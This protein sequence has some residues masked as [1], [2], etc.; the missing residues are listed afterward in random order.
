MKILQ[1][2]CKGLGNGGVQ[3]VIMNICRNTPE[4]CHDILL[5]TKDQGFYEKEF[6][7]LG[8]SIFFIPHYNG[9]CRIRRK[10]DFYIRFPRILLKTFLILKKEGPY[11]AIHCHNN[12]ESAL[13]GLAAVFAGVKIRIAHAHTGDNKFPKKY[14][15]AYLYTRILQYVMNVTCNV[16][17][18]CSELAFINLFGIKYLNA[19]SSYIIVN[20]IDLTHFKRNVN[21]CIKD[22]INIVNVGRYETNKNQLFILDMMPY[23]LKVFPNA[24]LFLVGFGEEYKSMLHNKT[25]HL[26]INDF[27]YFLPHT[28][29]VKDVL[30]TAHLFVFPS[31]H[32]GLG[33]V[34]LEAQAMEVPCLASSSLPRETDCGLVKYL[35]LEG[36]PILWAKEA[37]NILNGQHDLTLNKDKLFLFDKNS[38]IK[39]IRSIYKGELPC[40]LGL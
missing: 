12:L 35:P 8:G 28:S 7:A 23:I 10:L 4:I 36:G 15:F 24:R 11:D 27:V 29:N 33:I 14:L 20:P 9:P 18:A 21:Y 38:F 37:I 3:S 25:K 22:N 32:E 1:V 30:E 34:L 6:L 17:L 2:S 31:L 40:E 5:F 16:K 26:N 39:K 19:R 13:C